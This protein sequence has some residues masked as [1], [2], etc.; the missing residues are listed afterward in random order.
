LIQWIG[1]SVVSSQVTAPI[2][3]LDVT[4]GHQQPLLPAEILPG[5][6]LDFSIPI[7]SFQM[8]LQLHAKGLDDEFTIRLVQQ[9]GQHFETAR[10]KVKDYLGDELPIRLRF[11]EGPPPHLADHEPLPQTRLQPDEQER[12][13]SV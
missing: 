4:Q 13:S 1:F 9:S 7:D 8:N 11:H 10:L 3:T 2:F 5:R 6:V 12:D